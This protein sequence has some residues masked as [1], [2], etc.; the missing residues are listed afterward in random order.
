MRYLGLASGYL[1]G[2]FFAGG[3]QQARFNAAGTANT[4]RS[5]LY[6]MALQSR[7]IA[8][9]HAKSRYGT[10]LRSSPHA[11]CLLLRSNYIRFY[12]F[13]SRLYR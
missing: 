4:R 7:Q 6:G 10:A 8:A 2:F 5:W 9:Q 3:S 11:H 12:L 13:I 1:A